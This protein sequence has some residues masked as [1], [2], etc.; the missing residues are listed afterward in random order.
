[1]ISFYPLIRLLALVTHARALSENRCA[2][3]HATVT[4]FF[5]FYVV[6]EERVAFLTAIGTLSNTDKANMS[7]K[8]G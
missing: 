1:M 6:S 5:F 3:F 7:R 2:S 4:T 8:A